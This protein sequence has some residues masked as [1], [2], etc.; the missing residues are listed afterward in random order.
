MP[1]FSP[2]S[3]DMEHPNAQFA[4][5]GGKTCLFARL[6]MQCHS[7]EYNPMS[8]SPKAT[9]VAVSLHPRGVLG[10]AGVGGFV[11]VFEGLTRLQ[12]A[13][14]GILPGDCRDLSGAVSE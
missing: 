4:E 5:R 6:A 9:S 14:N 8:S 1:R 7:F 12:S 11:D 2:S 3:R 10:Q 13:A